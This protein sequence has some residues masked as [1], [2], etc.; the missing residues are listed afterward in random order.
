VNEKAIIFD[1][2]RSSFY[3]GPGIRTSVFFKGCPLRCVWCHNP[4]SYL[5]SKQLFYLNEKCRLCGGCMSVCQNKAHKVTSNSH[6]INHNACTLCKAC[7]ENCFSG[8]LKIMGTAMTVDEVMEIVVADYDFYKNS[9]GGITLTGGEPLMQFQFA[10]DLLKKCRDTGINTCVETSGFI[11]SDKFIQ[12]LPFIDVL[13][14]DYKTTDDHDHK[15]LT[16]VSNEIILKNLDLAY[17][18]GTTIILRCPI[19]MGIN[20]TEEHFQGIAALDKK[21]PNFIRI[22]LLPYHTTGNY[23]RKSIGSE[24]TLK[25]LKTT[26]PELAD[27]W[28]KRLKELNCSKAILG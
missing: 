23:K 21:Y 18:S 1:I 28:L 7:V 17:H 13:L 5:Q 26:S 3:D 19:I 10:M 15:R 2:Q 24:E 20:D 14:F 8:A 6:S 25:E 16:G 9:N 11:S 27:N 4:E 22:E 12:I